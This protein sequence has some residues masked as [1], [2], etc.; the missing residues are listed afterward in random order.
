[1]P[2][3]TYETMMGAERYESATVRAFWQQ[4]IGHLRGKPAHLLSYEDIKGRLRLREE[5]YRGLQDIPL[6][7]IVGSVGRYKDF[8]R[9]YLPKNVVSKERW[10]RIYAEANGGMGLPPIEVYQVGEVY[11]VRDGN[12]RVSV[13]REM[14]QESIQAY[15]T[16]VEMPAHLTALLLDQRIDAAAAYM[17]FMDEMGLR[18]VVGEDSLM[19]SEPSR[20]AE[21]IGHLALHRDVLLETSGEEITLE[22]AAAHWYH[23]VYSPAVALIREHDML[24]LARARTEADLYLWLV[25]HLCEL[26]RCYNG[27][28]EDLAPALISFLEKRRLP[29]PVTLRPALAS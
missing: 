21:F 6:E 9:T 24:R 20:Y 25:D 17:A 14:G 12:H 10:T 18:R 22:A 28:V 7:K 16:Q 15:V 3:T 19:L 29:V 26:E 4:I 11:F 1:M 23:Q 13:A 8:T 2:N 5:N 27:G